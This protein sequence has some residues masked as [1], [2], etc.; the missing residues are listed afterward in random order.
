MRILGVDPSLRSTGFALLDLE[1]RRVEGWVAHSSPQQE[2]GERLKAIA[3]LCETIVERERPD[4]VVMEGVILHRNPGTALAMGAVRG[5]LLLVFARAG[6]PVVEISPTRAKRML[7]GYGQASK[8]QVARMIRHIL[9]VD[10][11]S[12]PPDLTDAL[13]L[14]AGYALQEGVL[15]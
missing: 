7:T 4:R 8:E 9:G 13:A 5:A 12:W 1:D 11:S 2:L 6:L 14:A 10:L 15:R 3:Q